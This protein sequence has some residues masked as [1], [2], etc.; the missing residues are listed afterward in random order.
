MTIS[1]VI[2]EDLA[3]AAEYLRKCCEKSG[4]LEVKAHFTNVSD[5]TVFL[6]DSVVDLLFLDVEMPGEPGFALLDQISFSPKVI[7]TTSKA[8]YAYNAFEYN[9]TDFLKKPYTYQRFLQAVQKVSTLLEA[10]QPESGED[11]I[12]IKT[13]GKLVRLN[14]D[15]VLYI[16][17]MGD[18]VRFVTN[19]RKYIV[20]N[21]IKNLEEKMNRKAFMKIH[22]SYIVNIQKVDNI[23]EN[24]LFI[25]GVELSISKA[26]KADVIQR[27]NII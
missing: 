10:A 3:V 18:Y 15:D 16:E 17:S 21:T 26:H 9:V 20:H 6:N 23:R 13:E 2:I 19:D 27:I 14:N 22:R 4:A 1:C 24:V 5:A 12:F 8:D 11:H 25:R 7:L